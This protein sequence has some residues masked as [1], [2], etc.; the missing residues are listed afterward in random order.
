M[1]I[2]N[3][4]GIRVWQHPYH[5]VFHVQQWGLGDDPRSYGEKYDYFTVKECFSI[6][7]VNKVYQNLLKE[8]QHV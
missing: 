5:Q 2:F 6:E 3:K 7:E 1:I 8:K 4:D